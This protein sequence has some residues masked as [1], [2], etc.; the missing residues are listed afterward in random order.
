MLPWAHSE[1]KSQTASLSVQPFLYSSRQ[2]VAILYNGP[3]LPQSKF[4]FPRGYGSHLPAIHGAFGPPKSS[5][6]TASRSV[7][8]F[9]HCSP[10][11]SRVSA[12][13]PNSNNKWSK[14]FDIRPHHHRIGTVQSYTPGDA[15]G[16][17]PI[18]G[19]WSHPTQHP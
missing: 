13:R 12:M 9:F 7:R 6:K 8:P 2:R 10:Q 19:S 11:Q 18:H 4:P 1:S 15:N 16:T 5:I 17:H 14:Y 3:S